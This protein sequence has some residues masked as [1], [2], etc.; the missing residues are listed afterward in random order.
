M[1]YYTKE[2]LISAGFS[3]VGENVKISNKTSL[4]SISGSIGSNVRVDDFCILKGNI[5]FASY[6]HVAAFCMLSG[7][8]G[9]ITLQECATLSSGVH[10]YTGSDDYSANVLSSSTVPQEYT[11][12]IKGDVYLGYGAI[13]GCQSVLLPKA[14]L[15]DGA[16]VGAH[17]VVYSR[18][19]AG[20]VIVSGVIKSVNVKTRDVGIIK[21][22]IKLLTS[23]KK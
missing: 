11:K 13:V 2:E 7:M 6:N 3:S 1:S 14:L 12:T 9:K 5:I 19:P 20:A 17:C 23:I 22:Y 10:I 21:Q 15:E 4:Y 8:C 16:S 18:V